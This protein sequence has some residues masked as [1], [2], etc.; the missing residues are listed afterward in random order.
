MIPSTDRILL[1]SL[2]PRRQELL[3]QLG[4]RFEPISIEVTERPVA[5][6][7]AE[8]YVC[9]VASAKSEAGMRQRGAAVPV[10]AAD[11]EVILDGE[12]LGKPRDR[13][14][15]RMILARL[16]GRTHRVLTAVSLRWGDRHWRALS[17]TLVEIRE[18]SAAEA[19]AYWATGE[20]LDKAGGYAIQG[21]GALFIRRIEGSYTGVMGLPLYETAALLRH[22]G[23]DALKLLESGRAA[24]E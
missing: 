11:T 21:R 20:P 16:S 24:D 7:L 15:G 1:A 3:V 6:E 10:L 12:V 18:L 17:E 2:S 14:H 19:D 5:G 23:I 9:R 22:V 4:V 8:D 13:E